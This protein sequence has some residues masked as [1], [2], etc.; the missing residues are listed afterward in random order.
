MEVIMEET[1]DEDMPDRSAMDYTVDSFRTDDSMIGMS[2]ADSV[3][4]PPKDQ[5]EKNRMTTIVED[6]LESRQT[7]VMPESESAVKVTTPPVI[8]P[9]PVVMT[10]QKKKPAP[11]L[12]S[13]ATIKTSDRRM[14]NID[15]LK[16]QLAVRQQT[17]QGGRGKKGKPAARKD[18]SSDE[19]ESSSDD[20]SN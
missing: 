9:P 7:S 10:G 20:E 12:K 5:D 15:M 18:D 19:N 3:I 8:R 6:D 4:L 11:A 14:S 17:L 2:V 1:R 16:M 13:A